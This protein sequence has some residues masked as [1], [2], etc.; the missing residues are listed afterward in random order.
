VNFFHSERG[1]G[2]AITW[3]K[4][5]R[6]GLVNQQGLDSSHGENAAGTL[7]VGKTKANLNPQGGNKKKP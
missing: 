7:G 2:G 1:G 5:Q 4:E 6:S 3:L